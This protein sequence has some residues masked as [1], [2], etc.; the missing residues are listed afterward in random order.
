[1]N[2]AEMIALIQDG[3]REDDRVWADL[4]AGTGNFTW[5][6]RDLL[7]PTATIYAVDLD[8]RA[9]AAQRARASQP[10]SGPTIISLKA[11]FTRPLKLPPLDGVL[12]ANALHFVRDQR[13]T[14]RQITR[15]LRPGGRLL[16]VEYDLQ[17]AQRWTP[18]PLP[19]A[20]LQ[21]HIATA[22]LSAPTLIGT[23]RSPSTGIVLYAAL[24]TRP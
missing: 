17:R 16:V 3:V 15:Y 13:A 2:H 24:T 21:D 4:G 10:P 23:R 19:F 11:D 14:I 7:H 20:K 8:A 18:F 22:G 9:V 12:V 1:M 5:A 6:L